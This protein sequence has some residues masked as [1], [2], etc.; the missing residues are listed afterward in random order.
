M[1]HLQILK[2]YWWTLDFELIHTEHLYSRE[3]EEEKSQSKIT[4]CICIVRERLNGQLCA[5]EYPHGQRLSWLTAEQPSLFCEAEIVKSSPKLIKK[6]ADETCRFIP[7]QSQRHT[8]RLQYIPMS[9]EIYTVN[10][11]DCCFQ[12]SRCI[13]VI[14]IG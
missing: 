12:N 11:M 7:L 14:T 9:L 2:T 6:K 3:G 10:Y 1:D 13:Y 4:Y 5:Q 8:Q